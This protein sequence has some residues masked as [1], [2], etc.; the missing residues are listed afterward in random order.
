MCRGYA[1]AML[2]PFRGSEGKKRGWGGSLI[3]VTTVTLNFVNIC[4]K[5]KVRTRRRRHGNL[6]RLV[7][8]RSKGTA[9]WKKGGGDNI[10]QH[11]TLISVLQLMSMTKQSEQC[12]TERERESEIEKWRTG[13]DRT[14]F[15]FRQRWSVI[16]Q[17]PPLTFHSD[18]RSIN[19]HKLLA[20]P[21]FSQ[22]TLRW[23][24]AGRRQDRLLLDRVQVLALTRI[25][26]TGTNCCWRHR[27]SQRLFNRTTRSPRVIQTSTTQW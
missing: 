15:C 26:W 10:W 17:G 12:R 4:W 11:R 19:K 14:D 3:V 27:L 21:R 9:S 2:V 8:L 5:F 22:R 6:V 16:Y 24:R 23:M 25:V 7:F 20:F 13:R 18:Y 1:S